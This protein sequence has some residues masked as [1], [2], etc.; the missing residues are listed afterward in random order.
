[1]DVAI[2]SP[3]TSEECVPARFAENGTLLNAEEAIG[4]IVNRTGAQA[5]E[6]YYRN[7][8]AEAERVRGELFCSGDLGYRDDQGFFYFA[9]R[10]SEWIRVDSE[11]FAA[12]PVERILSRFPKVGL[13]AVYPV[14]DPRT[15]DQ[16]MATLQLDDGTRFDPATW[17]DFLAAQPDLGTKWAPRF[18]RVTRDAPVTATRKIDKPRLRRQAWQTADAVWWRPEPAGDYRPMTAE[19]RAGLEA[20]FA[21]NDRQ[22][23]LPAVRP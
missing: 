21:R 9:G 8:E 4:E 15:G 1:M 16:V 19:D 20:E 3:E 2:V 22:A 13:V 6:G 17:R 5:F 14:P 23:M 11:N 7:P 10:A 18:V 12:A